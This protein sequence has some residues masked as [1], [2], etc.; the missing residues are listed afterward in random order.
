M[1]PPMGGAPIGGSG[2][3]GAMND[4]NNPPPGSAIPP[5]M[6]GMPQMPPGMMGGAGPL[7]PGAGSM[8]IGAP[9]GGPMAMA[10]GQLPQG[11]QPQSNFPQMLQ[12]PPMPGG[13]M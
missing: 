9:G 6:P 2:V 1:T 4:I 11:M 5:Q 7:A 12:R 10:P 3:V 8:P 13:G